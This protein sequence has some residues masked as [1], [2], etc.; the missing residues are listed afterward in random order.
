MKCG[1]VVTADKNYYAGRAMLIPR[2]TTGKFHC[3]ALRTWVAREFT[4][5]I[6]FDDGLYASP[7]APFVVD[8]WWKEQLGQIEMNRITHESNLFL[9]ALSEDPSIDENLLKR[10]LASRYLSLLLQGVAYDTPVFSQGSHIFGDNAPGGM[11]VRGLGRLDH[12]RKPLK[13]L[14]EDLSG[15]HLEVAAQLAQGIDTIFSENNGPEDFLRLRKGFVAYLDGIKHLQSH[16]RLHQFVRALDAVIKPRQGD[17]TKK[18]KHRCQ[19]FAGR[20]P[21][22]IKRLGEL[23]ELRSA[24]KHLNPLDGKLGEYPKH[25]R[26]NIKAL[27]T[28]QAEL[29]A[30]FVYRKILSSPDVLA[31][32]KTDQAVDDMWAS[33][34]ANELISFWGDT[35][36]LHKAPD[37][38]FD[39]SL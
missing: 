18:F 31:H 13:V 9:L 28:Y 4:H 17:S 35:I 29:L 10:R 12:Y 6:N 7:H 36:D 22:D 33:K 26:D 1:W 39:E 8:D 27:R 38:F 23:Y 19:F 14:P 20:R 16:T 11:K 34:G 15:V 21:D 2:L 32:F 25:E 5:P 30:A 37:G 3:Y 24:A